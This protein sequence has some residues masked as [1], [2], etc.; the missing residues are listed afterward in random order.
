MQKSYYAVIPAN[1][2]YSKDVPD[3]AKLLYGEITALANETGYCWASNSYFAGL[4]GKSP[5]T[6]SR[7]V[8]QLAAAGFIQAIVDK[9]KANERQIW[10]AEPK[11]AIRKNADRGIGKNAARLSAKMP[12]P[13]RQ[14]SVDPIGKNAE[15]NNTVNNTLNK[16]GENTP[17]QPA[18]QSTTAS[19]FDGWVDSLQTDHRIAEGFTITQKVPATFFQ[20][21]LTRFT[22][23]ARTQPRKYLQQHDLSGHFLNWSRIEYEKHGQAKPA[24]APGSASSRF[25]TIGE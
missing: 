17:A 4:Y 1:V 25:R 18:N 22:A 9:G 7:W 14:K 23:L 12:N 2:R 5:D 16:E 19:Q 21:Y 6:I 10:L 24:P 13:Y 15:Q 3:G 8:S 11:G 20:D